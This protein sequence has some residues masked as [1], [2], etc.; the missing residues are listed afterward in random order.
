MTHYGWPSYKL[1]EERR[2]LLHAELDAAFFHLYGVA[3]DSHALI[4]S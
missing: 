2:L 4:Q 1:A 3:R